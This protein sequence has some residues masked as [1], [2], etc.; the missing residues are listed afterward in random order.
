MLVKF[1]LGL[2]SLGFSINSFA[3][4][5]TIQEWIDFFNQKSITLFYSS[6]YLPIQTLNH[7]LYLQQD[8]L[9][10]FNHELNNLSLELIEVDEST[11]VIKPLETQ[12][13]ATFSGIL[14][15]AIDSQSKKTI[16]NFKLISSGKIYNSNKG[17]VILHQ[18]K[19]RKTSFT[20]SSFGYISIDESIKQNLGHFS[21]IVVELTEKPLAIDK[22]LVTASRYNFDS[23]YSSSNTLLREDIENSASLN[24]DPL[25]TVSELAGSVSTGLSG[26]T[27][28]RG[29]HEN[30][31]L[32][33]FDNYVLRNPYHFNN[34][35]S[36]YSTINQSIV[37]GLD[38]YSG[39]FPIEYGGRLSSV[40]EAYSGD[41][42]GKK[43]NELGMDLYNIYYTRRNNNSDL[44]RQSLASIRTGVNIINERIVEEGYIQPQIYDAY[45]KFYQ[46][47]NENWSSSQHL[48]LARDE[49]AFDVRKANLIEDTEQANSL[50]KN[51]NFWSQWFYD[52]LQGMN[53]TIQV[54]YNQSFN[55]RRGKLINASANSF[56]NERIFSSYYGIKYQQTT[57]LNDNLS[58]SFGAE[59]FS[60][61]TSI[62]STRNIHHFGSF[63][64]QLGL[65]Q[66]SERQFDFENQGL[67]MTSHFNV[68]YRMNKK[69][70][71]D[72]GTRFEYRQWIKQNVFSPRLNL[73]YFY[74]DTSTFRLA[75]GRHQQ[76][77][78][79]DELYLEDEN[80]DY[81]LPTSADMIVLE[82][83]KS[84]SNTLE[85]RI[86]AYKKE[87]S[88]SQPYYENI[89]NEL[90]ILP[91]LYY[92]R[93]RIAPQDSY[94]HGAEFTLK[95]R[96]NKIQWLANYTF[97]N[98]EDETHDI[99]HP[100]SWDQHHAIKLSFHMPIK[101]WLF[102]FSSNIH[103]GWPQTELV[104][105]DGQYSIGER[106]EETFKAH[107]E[108]DVK[109]SKQFITSKG[110]WVLNL[111]VNNALNY[112]NTCCINYSLVDD[113]LKVEE[114]QW[115]PITPNVSLA[116]YWD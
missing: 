69:L 105:T 55:K 9:A 47:L 77:Q 14:I 82:Y 81:F 61:E 37:D 93:I 49:I 40:L 68:R 112:F 103:S 88:Q 15:R 36:L 13:S 26:K 20:V 78:Y 16:K 46:E 101:S 41:N 22:I 110:Q 56:V 58:T 60:E 73:S 79:I 74:D 32:I 100:R 111:Q 59:V 96:H 80:P 2:L 28:T 1:W 54:Y 21:S 83:N 89:F 64:E 19:S 4:S 71:M 31:S 63:V 6:D 12:D 116:Y 39:V 66:D 42:Y 108:L 114:K 8:S 94:A 29:G 104:Q 33:L 91:D 87:Y 62:N 72:F 45:F 43:N 99:Y 75:L 98:I 102:N 30:E 11:Y 18:L 92:D 53:S 23:I 17:S 106:N 67:V 84:F 48:L 90:H 113:E 70:V 109:F 52:N 7:S 107:I 85:L 76:A 5:H 86:E 65:E 3:S 34:F 38:F 115:L 44:S 51:K 25:R 95:G 24:N 27:R 97:S 50:H 10:N 35:F 57:I